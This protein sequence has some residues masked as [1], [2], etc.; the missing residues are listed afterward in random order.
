MTV[1]N[2][3]MLI[4]YPDSLGKNIKELTEVLEQDFG[5]A[6]GGVH[7]LPFFPSTD[8]RGFAPVDY[9]DVDPQFGT[10]ENVEKLGEKY[11]LVFDFM[12][13]HIS[14]Q[15]EY[16]KDFKK[17]KDASKWADLF[18]SWDKFWP[19]GHPT[20]EDIDLIY[21]RKDRAPYQEIH[22]DDVTTEKLWNT[23]G[24]E[25]ID[26]DVRTQ[27]TKDFIKSTLE[28]IIDHGADIIRLDA[29]A[30]AVKK[31]GTNDFFV[32][33][34]IWALCQSVR[35]KRFLRTRLSHFGF[36]SSSLF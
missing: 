3:A 36:W 10:W 2:K 28:S 30:Y 1:Q 29:F 13:N 21:K 27:V 22:F 19:E 20:Q 7:L 18:L 34:E 6:V 23:F 35:M 16:Y 8:D 11:Y 32:E 31:L 5:D 26:M 15:S 14:R 33:P 4:T 17:N 9:K 25:Q 24:E 12:I